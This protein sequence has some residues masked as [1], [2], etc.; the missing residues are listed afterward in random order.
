M[1]IAIQA[2][3]VKDG[4]LLDVFGVRHRLRIIDLGSDNYL[5]TCENNSIDMSKRPRIPSRPAPQPPKPGE[6]TPL[7]KGEEQKGVKIPPRPSKPPV[8]KNKG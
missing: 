5:I 4:S 3:K 1:E 6:E 7:K 8:K 2:G